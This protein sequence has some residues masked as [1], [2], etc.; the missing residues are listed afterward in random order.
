MD[1]LSRREIHHSIRAPPARPYRFFDF[2]FYRRAH[3]GVADVGIYLHQKIPA[4]DHRLTFGVVDVRGDDRSA[5]GNFPADKLRRY[6]IAWRIRTKIFSGML[7]D[8][9]LEL[10]DPLVLADSDVFHFRSN[11]AFA[12][13]VKL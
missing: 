1:I 12:R 8:A 6:I 5:L 13:I 10:V 4:D 9:F 3:G 7:S 11:D 2:L